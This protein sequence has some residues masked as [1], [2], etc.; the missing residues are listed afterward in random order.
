MVLNIVAAEATVYV[1]YGLVTLLPFFLVG[2]FL[3]HDGQMI[4]YHRDT[5]FLATTYIVGI[6]A[7]AMAS[8]A[9]A[10]IFNFA[11]T[12]TVTGTVQQS[13]YWSLWAIFALL[14]SAVLTM[15]PVMARSIEV[16]GAGD[17]KSLSIM[18]YGNMVV[19]VLGVSAACMLIEW[20]FLGALT[21]GAK[22][23]IPNGIPFLVTLP[24]MAWHLWVVAGFIY[25]MVTKYK[26]KR[27]QGVYEAG[28]SVDSPVGRSL[29]RL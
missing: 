6:L 4:G 28:K 12:A 17:A 25:Y 15:W 24:Y 23:I 18:V 21:Y 26:R 19:G 5:W 13:T 10:L 16:P 1:L 11:L 3:L 22:Q 2:R 27:A 7:A 8:M 29:T 9:R 20:S 14:Q